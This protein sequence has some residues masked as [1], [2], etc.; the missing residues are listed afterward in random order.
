[1]AATV[2][3]GFQGQLYIGNAGSAAATQVV[4]RT[5]ISFNLTKEL[6][7]TTA[8]G[9]GTSIPLGTEEAVKVTAEIT[10]TMILKTEDANVATLEAAAAGDT[11][12]A[13]LLKKIPTGATKFDGDCHVSINSSLPLGDKQQ[14]EIT[15]KPT[16]RLRAPTFA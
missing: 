15:F 10:C 12:L 9:V 16:R 2:Y 5:D 7:D 13:V 4:E 14:M 6:V 8:A 1:M 3:R 11:T